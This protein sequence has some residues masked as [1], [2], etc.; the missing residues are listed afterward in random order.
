MLRSK[1]SIYNHG[2]VE[3]VEIVTRTDEF[4]TPLRGKFTE[5][6]IYR[7]WYRKL[8]ITAEDTYFANAD[9]KV[10]SRKVALRGDV[11]VDVKWRAKIDG[12]YFSVYRV[13]YSY[14]RNETEVSFV[15]VVK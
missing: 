3:F 11:N 13:F 1:H 4:G 8:G 2:I 9:D 5:K 10:L 14:K 7:D 12:K 6:I 15:E